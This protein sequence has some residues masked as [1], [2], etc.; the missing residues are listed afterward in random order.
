[1]NDDGKS[2]SFRWALTVVAQ[3]T[4]GN[5]FISTEYGENQSSVVFPVMNID[6][7]NGISGLSENEILNGQ[8]ITIDGGRS[9]LNKLEKAAY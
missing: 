3:D 9:I 6:L 4:Q 7:V 8:V 5:S 1:M 2:Q